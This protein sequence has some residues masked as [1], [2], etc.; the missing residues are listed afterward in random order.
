MVNEKKIIPAISIGISALS[1]FYFLCFFKSFIFLFIVFTAGIALT[2]YSFFKRQPLKSRLILPI[3]AGFFAA[4]FSY[5]KLCGNTAL[6]QTLAELSLVENISVCL[7]TD[8]IPSADSYYKAEAAV[9]SCRYKD[10]SQFSAHGNV[11][12]FIPSEFIAQNNSGGITVFSNEKN[13]CRFFVKG[14]KFSAYGKFSAKKEILKN[15]AF[16]INKKHLPE[17]NSWE[18]SF[19]SFRAHLRF[20]LIRMLYGWKEAGGLLLALLSANKDFLNPQCSASFK[21]AGLSHILALSGMHLS[22][23]VFSVSFAAK[24]FSKRKSVPF[25]SA[26]F[27]FCFVWFAGISPSLLRAFA[28]VLIIGAGISMNVKPNVFAVMCTAAFFHLILKPAHALTFAFMLSYGAL[29]GILLFGSAF[30]KCLKGKIPDFLLAGIASS[31]GAVFFTAPIIIFHT[32]NIPLIGTAATLAV[33]P[34]VSLF[35]ILGIVF[36]LFSLCFPFSAEFLGT[37][38]NIIYNLIFS[39]ANFFASFPALHANSLF[40]K[41]FLCAVFPS[42]GI[43]FIIKLHRLN[44]KRIVRLT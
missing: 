43:T 33:S 6:P 15:A 28:M 11:I 10:F 22:I 16:F 37:V 39:T 44:K 29:S 27:A 8:A 30:F 1:V 5:C 18:N 17:F 40:S 21:N 12:V 36:I 4:C 26:I 2:I 38:L 35:L 13:S 24:L 23:A 7:K 34:M 42:I 14:T 20:F 25:F 19:L 3:S 41:I 32:G 9:I 31:L